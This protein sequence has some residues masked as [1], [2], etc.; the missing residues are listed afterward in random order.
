MQREPSRHRDISAR[1]AYENNKT[2]ID[3]K[4]IIIDLS[5]EADNTEVKPNSKTSFTML[6][7]I[8]IVITVGFATY[9]VN[10]T[11]NQ[12]QMLSIMSEVIQ[13]NKTHF[14][15][16]NNEYIATNNENEDSIIDVAPSSAVIDTNEFNQEKDKSEDME[17]A[18]DVPDN[19]GDE[20]SNIEEQVEDSRQE[21]EVNDDSESKIDSGMEVHES[22]IDKPIE[23][24][25][26]EPVEVNSEAKINIL[27]VDKLS[28]QDEGTNIV[29]QA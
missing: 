25:K 20:K 26:N 8:L 9:V 2:Q 16:E 4:A 18:L 22:V 1:E 7:I 27:N 11:Y 23:V 10:T 24:T 6:I 5:P 21:L 3:E 19:D 29:I 28:P 13:N 17:V 14:Q 15:P 12:K